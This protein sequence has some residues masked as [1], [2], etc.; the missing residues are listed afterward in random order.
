MINKTRSFKHL[1]LK[2]RQIIF[3]MRYKENKTLQ[4]IA[5]FIGKSKSAISMELKRNKTNL[6]INSK[7]VHDYIQNIES[8]L[9]F[10]F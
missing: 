2:D 10:Y 1:T 7:Q 8:G 4:K 6:L 5:D 3:H 9:V